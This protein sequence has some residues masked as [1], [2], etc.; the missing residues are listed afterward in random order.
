M[1]RPP[2]VLRIEIKNQSHDFSLWLPLF[3]I[4]PFLLLA[5][6]ALAPVI[7]AL[8]IIFWWTRWGRLMLYSGPIF[9]AVFCALRGLE[10]DVKQ[11][12]QR[13]HLSFR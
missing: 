7:L 9:F 13:V 3:V 6:I 5:A 12:N 1:I 8:A 11:R 2:S 4:W 10:I